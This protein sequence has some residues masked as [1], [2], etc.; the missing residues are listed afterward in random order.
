MAHLNR[1]EGDDTLSKA[2][3]AGVAPPKCPLRFSS[4]ARHRLHGVEQTGLLDRVLNVGI[5][6]Q[7]VDLTVDVFD[8]N[9]EAVEASGLWKLD[10]AAEVARQVL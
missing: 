6:E 8:G 10:L 5:D 1:R 2:G 4:H 7:A 9:L 3:E